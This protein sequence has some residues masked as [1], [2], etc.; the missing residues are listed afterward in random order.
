MW[1]TKPRFLNG[2]RQAPGVA[3][4]RK[5]KPRTFTK[6][7]YESEFYKKFSKSEYELISDFTSMRNK[8][9][10]KHLLCETITEKNAASI[11]N[12]KNENGPCKLC[13]D[14]YAKSID[15]YR[16]LLKVRGI[17]DY[18]LHEIFKKSGQVYGKFTHES[19]VCNYNNFEM[20][21]SD[22]YSSHRQGCPV[23]KF[24]IIDSK[25]SIEI[26]KFLKSKNI[27]F[28]TEIKIEDLKYKDNLRIDIYIP[29]IDVY[30]EYDGIQH[31]RSS[32]GSGKYEKEKNFK[33]IKLRDKIKNKYFR[34]N[35]LKLYRIKYNEDHI[36]R[37]K[38]ILL[39]NNIDTSQI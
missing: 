12:T 3:S 2:E 28:K 39:E 1:K 27:P 21:I 32:F 26:K 31:F 13:F 35:N 11:I 38:E 22:M 30:I 10:F 5:K 4:S 34:D 14:K 18:T 15:E 8:I 7:S 29:S 17:S 25:A 24:K 33:I 36:S 37:I 6:E 19:E 20:R 23:C 9:K 16:L